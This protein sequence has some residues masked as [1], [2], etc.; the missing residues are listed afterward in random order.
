MGDFSKGLKVLLIAL[1]AVVGSLSVCGAASAGLAQPGD[2]FPISYLTPPPNSVPGSVSGTMGPGYIAS[3]SSTDGRYVFFSSESDNLVAGTGLE[4]NNLFRKDRQTG[5]V[6]LVNRIDGA[7]GA[8]FEASVYNFSVSGDGNLVAMIV[9][10]D[11]LPGDTD[12]EADLVLRNIAA[13]TTKS[14]TSAINTSVYDADISADG[15][16]VA[17]NTDLAMSPG[18]GNADFDVYRM[19]LSDGVTKIVSA[20]NGTT[21]AGN[22]QSG[23]PSISADG[24]WVA[25]S[26]RATNLI[27]GFTNANGNSSDIWVRNVDSNN[28]YLVSSKYNAAAT[29]GDDSSEEPVIAGAPAAVGDVKV[30]YTSYSVD[31]AD[32]ATTDSSGAASVYLKD[33]PNVP[34]ELISRKSGATGANADSR[35]H[36][37]SIS[38]DASRV[39]FS[40]DAENL[41][42]V[43]DYYGVYMRDRGDLSTSMISARNSYAVEGGISGDG[44]VAT[45]SEAG[46]ATE[47]SDP[48]LPSIFARTV[49][50]GQIE[51]ISRPKGT[52]LVRAAGFASYDYGDRTLSANGRYFVFSSGSSRLPDSPGGGEVQ[53]VYRRDLKT[54]D[55]EL[56]SR[57]S[58]AAGALPKG[59]QSPSVSSDGNRIAFTAYGSLDPAD[60][61]EDGDTYVRDMTTLT[62]TLVSRADGTDGAVGN[63]AS[64]ESAISGD[65]NRVAFISNAPNLGGS[66]T[67]YSVF[68]RDLAAGRTYLVSRASTEGGAVAN[69]ESGSPSISYDGSKVAFESAANNLSPDDASNNRSIYVRDLTSNETL[70]ASREPGLTGSALPGYVYGTTISGNGGRIAFATADSVSVP[71]SGTWPVGTYQ[72]VVRDLADGA[73]QLASVSSGGQ[74][75]DAASDNPSLSRDGSILAFDTSADN[76]RDD[77]GP[78]S[79]RD[80]VVRDLGTGLVSGPPAFGLVPDR[81]SAWQ[82][83]VSDNGACVA[84]NGK[85]HNAVSGDLG[86]I[87]SRYIYAR[88]SGC[89]DPQAVLPALTSVS[90][91]PAKFRVAKKATAKVA[92]RKKRKTSRGTKI[93]FTLNI[94]ATVTMRIDRKV[95]GRRAG[96][97]CV[98]PT[99]KNKRKKACI[100]YFKAG[101]LTRKDVPAGKRVV[102][103]TGRIGRKALKPG[104]YRVVLRAASPSGDSAG[105]YRSFRVVKK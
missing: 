67:Y 15:A 70:L 5:D 73:N 40:S 69:A 101:V 76:L 19:R 4:Q 37:P 104:R 83:A 10:D 82:P 66:G 64:G 45:W 94:P 28:T 44:Q 16:Y 58:G 32:N 35:A 102:P 17:F 95:P 68:V 74:P 26:S 38:D 100:R 31:L 54:G 9:G 42:P 77:I 71:G 14:L 30:A 53:M 79:Y 97:K 7:Q 46:G 59:A 33:M 61:N 12:G 11:V 34:S 3:P 103:F 20:L 49:P 84:F 80:V 6:E 86:D 90:L 60:P 99:R 81:G 57:A 2:T 27:A 72:I 50:G 56:V 48:D 65:G 36:T 8:P 92:A 87:E 96:T 63:Q 89:I 23:E 52:Q 24:A 91:K 41:G 78:G 18:D 93:R 55:I 1:S 105:V 51:L 75:A 22:G 85:G 88:G 13:G 98:R 21:T 43:K 39:V 29:G 47:D 62:T 25:F